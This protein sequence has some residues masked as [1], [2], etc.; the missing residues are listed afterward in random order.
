MTKITLCITTHCIKTE[1][2][3]IYT[4]IQNTVPS[5]PST[6]LIENIID[7]FFKKSSI[8]PEDV[9]IHIGYDKRNNRPI[10]EQYHQNLIELKN[11]FKHYELIVN[12]SDITDPIITA[13]INFLNLINSVKTDVYI[14]WEHDWILKREIDLNPI[15]DEVL[16]NDKVN[17]IRLN[18][19]DNN[20]I[21]YDN[22]IQDGKI[23]S[24]KIPLIA[25]F[26]WSNNPY[27]CKTKIFQN[28]WSTFVYS[29]SNEGGFVEG[30]LNEFYKFYIDKMG[31]DMASEKFGCFVYG[32]WDDESIVEHLNGNAWY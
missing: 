2:H 22:L 21:R 32:N 10:D 29:T 13:P 4:G 30:P 28:W 3:G 1:S 27:I 7:D 9:Y 17:Y 5:A 20:N 16:L 31:F 19:F 8:D 15:I 11:K 23:P 6:R 14:F 26:R 18:Q 25:T 12:S 24:D